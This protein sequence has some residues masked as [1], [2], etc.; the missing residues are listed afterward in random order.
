MPCPRKPDRP[1]AWVSK[2]VIAGVLDVSCQYFDSTIRPRM[3]PEH[4][5]RGPEGL[6][7][8]GR[9]AVEAFADRRPRP[10]FQDL[11]VGLDLLLDLGEAGRLDQ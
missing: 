7:F 9:G 3:R 5:R 6:R 10:R 2:K 1:G 4:V 11:D 8:Y